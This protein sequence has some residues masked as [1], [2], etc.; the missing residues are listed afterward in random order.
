MNHRPSRIQTTVI[1]DS[2][3]L[4]RLAGGFFLLVTLFLSAF[5]LGNRATE[6]AQYPSCDA[7]PV[8][9]RVIKDFNWAER[10]TWQRGYQM[11]KLSRAHE[12]RMVQ[13]SGSEVSR[14]YCMAKAH[15][16]N[17]DHRTVYYMIS[18]IGGFVGRNWDVT[19]C[20]M[21]LDPWLNHDGSCRTMR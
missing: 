5:L 6:S 4:T 3:N 18:D 20:V 21:G 13:Y 19:H 2:G 17:G 14:R 15:F 9:Y 10:K 12:H 7:V 8:E 11:V 1:T 16:T